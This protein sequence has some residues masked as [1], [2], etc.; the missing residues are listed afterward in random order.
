MATYIVTVAVRENII[1]GVLTR[2]TLPSKNYPE[3]ICLEKAFS[4]AVDGKAEIIQDWYANDIRL[5]SRDEIVMKVRVESPLPQDDILSGIRHVATQCWGA[6]VGV[7]EATIAP[8]NPIE[9]VVGN[10]NLGK[11]FAAFAGSFMVGAVL[12][13]VVKLFRG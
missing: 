11:A 10:I 6:P 1:T 12:A 4:Q 8:Y 2:L 9:G 3:K 13:I 5:F 7:A